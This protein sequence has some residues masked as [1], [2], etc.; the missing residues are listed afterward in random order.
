MAIK[1]IDISIR[2][3]M[4]RANG[5]AEAEIEGK[6]LWWRNVFSR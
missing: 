6:K 5:R 4:D 3:L 2:F 1:S